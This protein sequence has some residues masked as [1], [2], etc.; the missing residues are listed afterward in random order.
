VQHGER[1]GSLF[2]EDGQIQV[3]GAG[4]LRQRI[5]AHLQR[6]QQG[7]VLVA[8]EEAAEFLQVSVPQA[9]QRPLPAFGVLANEGAYHRQR[10]RQVATLPRYLAGYRW[11]IRNGLPGPIGQQ[12]QCLIRAEYVQRNGGR[13]ERLQDL[14]VTGG[15]QVTGR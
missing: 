14:G 9:V 13:V 6:R 7:G 10:Q 1:D 12:T 5:H 8:G 3:A 11:Q 2:R 15:D 4:V